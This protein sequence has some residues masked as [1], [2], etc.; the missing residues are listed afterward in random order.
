MIPLPGSESLPCIG[1]WQLGQVVDSQTRMQFG[2]LQKAVAQSQPGVA[3]TDT[4]AGGV[5]DTQKIRRC[6]MKIEIGG[7]AEAEA[8]GE[9]VTVNPTAWPLPLQAVFQFGDTTLRD[10]GRARDRRATGYRNHR[11]AQAG[12]FRR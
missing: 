5:L 7:D 2:L 1:G 10:V 4:V 6:P 9:V 12:A 11:S 3:E 8:A